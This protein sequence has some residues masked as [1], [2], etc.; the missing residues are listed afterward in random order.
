M[1]GFSLAPIDVEHALAGQLIDT[2]DEAGAAGRVDADAL[3]VGAMAGRREARARGRR[4]RRIRVPF[5]DAGVLVRVIHVAQ[6]VA[7]ATASIS[8]L[9]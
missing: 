7:T 1:A 5:V 8:L 4:L 2:Y 9:R 3:A 6:L